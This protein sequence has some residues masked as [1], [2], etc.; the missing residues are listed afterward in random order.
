[1]IEC[2]TT[3][4]PI[5]NMHFG[6]YPTYK[7]ALDWLDNCSEILRRQQ[8]FLIISTFSENYQFEHKARIKQAKWFKQAKSELAKWCLG[9]IRVTQDPIMI[10]KINTPAMHK[11]MPL[12]C[13]AV[14]DIS[15]AK[16]KAYQILIEGNLI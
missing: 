12:N 14:K 9:M 10:K 2:D 5:V 15:S 13:I 16:E 3:K 11:G 1:M 6:S 8:K 4:W 7:D